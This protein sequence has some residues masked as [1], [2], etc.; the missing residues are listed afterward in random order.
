MSSEQLIPNAVGRLD[1][2]VAAIKEGQRASVIALLSERELYVLLKKENAE[3]EAAK[4]KS[5][6]DVIHEFLIKFATS[7]DFAERVR[8]SLGTGEQLVIDVHEYD[9]GMSAEELEK[10]GP[11]I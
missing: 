9:T 10:L 3:E 5:E 6:F 11:G 2:V 8:Q 4:A 1:D 7:P